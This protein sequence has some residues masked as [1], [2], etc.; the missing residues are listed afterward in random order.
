MGKRIYPRGCMIPMNDI[1]DYNR[2]PKVN[3][4]IAEFFAENRRGDI[5]LMFLSM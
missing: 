3:A 1:L 5:P 4:E 2:N